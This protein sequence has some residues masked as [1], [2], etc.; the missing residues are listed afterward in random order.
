VA[1]GRADEAP[2]LLDPLVDWVST[3]AHLFAA[4]AHAAVATSARLPD[5]GRDTAGAGVH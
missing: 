2:L 4:T 1:E 3:H 5:R